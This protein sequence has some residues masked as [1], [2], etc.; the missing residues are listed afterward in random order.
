M[1]K[2]GNIN[3][4]GSPFQ[5]GIAQVHMAYQNPKLLHNLN[6]KNAERTIAGG[7]ID[8]HFPVN[9]SKI[10][11]DRS[12]LTDLFLS[13][14]DKHIKRLHETAAN[15]TDAELA[16]AFNTKLSGMSSIDVKFPKFNVEDTADNA[17]FLRKVAPE[18]QNAE[19]KALSNNKVKMEILLKNY[20]LDSSVGT[21]YLNNYEHKIPKNLPL[22]ERLK[23]ITHS[24]DG[25]G[26]QAYQTDKDVLD[27]YYAKGN[28]T[29]NY[30]Q[31]D[32]P[33]NVTTKANLNLPQNPSPTQLLEN[34]RNFADGISLHGSETM[35]FP[36]NAELGYGAGQPLSYAAGS[37]NAFPPRMLKHSSETVP[38]IS[39]SAVSET[40]SIIP[41]SRFKRLN[42][43]KMSME[44]RYPEGIPENK[45]DIYNVIN[46]Y[47]APFKYKNLKENQRFNLDGK[48]NAASPSNFRDW[49]RSVE[50]DWAKKSS[51]EGNIGS[52]IK[53]LK[54][55]G[56]MGSALGGTMY[57]IN[58]VANP[59][60]TEE[61]LQYQ[62]QTIGDNLKFAE[63]QY[64]KATTKEEREN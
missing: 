63:Q 25:R 3:Y 36:Y 15:V 8:P 44:N 12:T 39:R 26:G 50:K 40:N 35:T 30:G 17:K 19:L 56:G 54:M 45:K 60:Y 32:G 22:E 21:R 20:Y 51:I 62:K 13:S 18:L 33:L 38:K 59:T 6:L 14:N 23:R 37:A 16:A 28:S 52:F 49:E 24:T 4:S 46:N 29:I 58:K 10:N 9:S 11:M 1:Y 27:V 53:G 57:G 31:G 43:I 41:S 7:T 5:P 2:M 34:S 55:T 48:R 47:S 61:Q 42:K 64:E